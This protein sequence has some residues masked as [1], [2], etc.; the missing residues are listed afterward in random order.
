MQEALEIA[1]ITLGVMS[2]HADDEK[3]QSMARCILRE[4]KFQQNFDSV[5]GELHSCDQV[6]YESLEA[7]QR[8]NT[9]IYRSVFE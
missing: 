4:D 3:V 1:E 9:S 2:D 5:K 8:R 7:Y 6:R